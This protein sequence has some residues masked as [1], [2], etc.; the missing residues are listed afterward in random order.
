MMELS[1]ELESEIARLTK[2]NEQLRKAAEDMALRS[3]KAMALVVAIEEA[4]ARLIKE[5]GR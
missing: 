2:E 5:L 4:T 1:D 3:G